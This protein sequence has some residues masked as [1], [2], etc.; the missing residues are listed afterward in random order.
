MPPGRVARSKF[1]HSQ[2]WRLIVRC[3]F[4]DPD[5]SRLHSHSLR[6][7]LLKIQYPIRKMRLLARNNAGEISLTKYFV[8]DN[9]P[10]VCHTLAHVGSGDRRGQ[11]RKPDGWYRQEQAWLRQ[12]PV[13]R[14]T[15]QTRWLAILLGRH[16]LHRQI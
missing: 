3:Y 16:L 9:I 10:P 12:D 1:I 11:L 2:E 6:R 8:S 5:V 15:S 7:S 14:R 13:L 4:P